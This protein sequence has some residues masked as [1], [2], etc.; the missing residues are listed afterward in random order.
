M[1]PVKT[2]TSKRLLLH[3]RR[4][5]YR[6][7][8]KGSGWEARSKIKLMNKVGMFPSTETNIWVG[9]LWSGSSEV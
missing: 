9:S 1:F 5:E 8:F 3:S 6:D 4:V 2:K 7:G